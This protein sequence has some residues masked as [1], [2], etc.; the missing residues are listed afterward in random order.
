MKRIVC[1]VSIFLLVSPIVF[2]KSGSISCSKPSTFSRPSYTTMKT[3]TPTVTK[4]FTPVKVTTS[5]STTF[6]KAP[7]VPKTTVT[8]VSKPVTAPVGVKAT[9][10]SNTPTTVTTKQVT[11]ITPLTKTVNVSHTTQQPQTVVV[12][13]YQSDNSWLY[14]LMFWQ[15]SRDRNQSQQI[16]NNGSYGELPQE[17]KEE[18]WYSGYCFISACRP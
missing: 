9:V 16:N 17:E 7:L 3:S 5:Q 18:H 12:H 11:P 8:S 4:T 15:W 13:H 2:A 1:L 6:T 14:W 10:T